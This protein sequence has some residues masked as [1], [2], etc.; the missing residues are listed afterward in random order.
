MREREVFC[1]GVS[2]SFTKRSKSFT[3][4]I[5]LVAFIATTVWTPGISHAAATM[6][7]GGQEVALPYQAAL[8]S[9]MRIE[10]PQTLGKIEDLHLGKGPAI[11]HIQT[12]HGHY[13][14]QQQIRQI[15]HHLEKNYGVTTV[16]VEGGISQL[17]PE[18]LNFFPQDKALTLKLNEALTKDAMVKGPELFLLDEIQQKKQYGVRST[19]DDETRKEYGVRRT[20]NEKTVLRS[21]VRRTPSAVPAVAYGIENAELY[22]ANGASFVDVLKQKE[23]TAN[24]LAQM[25]EGINRIS[26]HQLNDTLRRFIRQQEAFEK[27]LMPLDAWLSFMKDQAN[28][29]LKLDL[30]DAANQVEWPM[31]LRIFKLREISS[32]LDKNAFVMERK[33][34]LAAIKRF[35]STR[36]TEYGVRSNEKGLSQDAVRLTPYQSIETLLQSQSTSVQLPD[37]ETSF[38]FEDMVQRLPRDFNYDLFPNVR[39]FIGTLLLTSELKANRLMAETAKLADKISEG[40]AKTQAEKDLVGLLKDYRRLQKLFALELTP[41]DYEVI[42]SRKDGLKPS[43]IVKRF[44]STAYGLRS[45]AKTQDERGTP[46]AL[47]RTKTVVFAH[48][49]ELDLLYASALKF[50]SG[51]KERDGAMIRRIE[52]RLKET[53]A[54][55][56]AVITGGFHSKP[57]DDY[58]SSKD[59]T[60]ALI[61]PKITG[62]DKE[63]Y[64]NY[65]RNVLRTVAPRV[66]PV[67]RSKAPETRDPRSEIQ[68]TYEARYATEPG[69]PGV[70]ADAVLVAAGKMQMSRPT[71]AELQRRFQT[72]ARVADVAAQLEQKNRALIQAKSGIAAIDGRRSEHRSAGLEAPIKLSDSQIQKIVKRVRRVLEDSSEDALIPMRMTG[73]NFRLRDLNNVGRHNWLLGDVILRKENGR[74][75]LGILETLTGTV[76]SFR[77]YFVHRRNGDTARRVN[78]RSD[79]TGFIAVFHPNFIRSELRVLSP[80]S[81][82]NKIK[83][84][85]AADK[86]E[87]SQQ[88]LAMVLAD[89][90]EAMARK[91]HYVLGLATGS[92][93]VR[94]YELLV[95]AA[96]QGKIDFSKVTTFN[97]DEYEGL[98]PEYVGN[99]SPQHPGDP[100]VSYK[101]FMYKHFFR[102]LF[103][104]G[105]VTQDWINTHVN[106]FDSHS[107]DAEAMC[108]AYEAKIAELG[109][110]DTWIGG[111]GSDGHIAFNE[112]KGYRI[113]NGKQ[114]PVDS[115]TTPDSVSRRVHLP[116]MTEYANVGF[117]R[118]IG[119]DPKNGSRWVKWDRGR[120]VFVKP[121]TPGARPITRKEALAMVPKTAFSIGMRTY[122]NARHQI[123]LATGRGKADALHKGMD[124]APDNDVALSLLQEAA[125]CDLLVDTAAAVLL[126][127]SEGRDGGQGVM[128]FRAAQRLEEA[129]RQRE[130]AEAKFKQ[131]DAKLQ[132]ALDVAFPE[133]FLVGRTGELLEIVDYEGEGRTFTDGQGGRSALEAFR[134]AMQ[135][136]S[137]NRL[138]VF[139][140]TYRSEK[141]QVMKWKVIRPGIELLRGD[142][143]Q[144]KGEEWVLSG[145]VVNDKGDLE[146]GL[147][148]GQGV[149]FSVSR[150]ALN[151]SRFGRWGRWVSLRTKPLSAEALWMHLQDVFGG[152]VEW[153]AVAALGLTPVSAKMVMHH[154]RMAPAPIISALSDEDRLANALASALLELAETAGQ[155]GSFVRTAIGKNATLRA[156]SG[157]YPDFADQ[158][159]QMLQLEGLDSREVERFYK[160]YRNRIVK[161]LTARAEVRLKISGVIRSSSPEV[162]SRSEQ[163]KED[164]NRGFA[165][166][167]VETFNHTVPSSLFKVTVLDYY[168]SDDLRRKLAEAKEK[169]RL[170]EAAVRRVEAFNHAAP[171]SYFTVTVLHYNDADDLDRKL[172]SAREKLQVREAAVSRVEAFN[173]TVPSSMTFGVSVL[174]SDDAVDLD[175]KLESAREKLA[176][177]SEAPAAMLRTEKRTVQT[178]QDIDHPS[179]GNLRVSTLKDEDTGNSVTVAPELF[180]H[181]ISIKVNGGKTELLSPERGSWFMFPWSG[182]LE[183]EGQ[184]ITI[185]GEVVDLSGAPIDWKKDGKT[186]NH[187]FA[188]TRTPWKVI[189]SGRKQMTGLPMI[190][191]EIPYI[192]LELNTSDIQGVPEKFR[193]LRVRRTIFVAAN[194]EVAIQY[195]IENTGTIAKKVGFGEHLV[196]NTPNRDQWSGAPSWLSIQGL[197]G[198]QWDE[199]RPVSSGTPSGILHSSDYSILMAADPEVF[200]NQTFWTPEGK[201]YLG[202]EPQT[203]PPGAMDVTIQPGKTLRTWV[204]LFFSPVKRVSSLPQSQ[205]TGAGRGASTSSPLEWMGSPAQELN[206]A[207]AD[208]KTLLQQSWGIRPE[209]ITIEQPSPVLPHHAALRYVVIQNPEQSQ[210]SVT[211]GFTAYKGGGVLLSG[212]CFNNIDGSGNLMDEPIGTRSEKGITLTPRL[213]RPFMSSERVQNTLKHGGIG[214]EDIAGFAGRLMT[215]LQARPDYLVEV[216][217]AADTFH[218][219]PFDIMPGWRNVL[220][221]E[222]KSRDLDPAAFAAE[223]FNQ[224]KQ[225]VIDTLKSRAEGRAFGAMWKDLG[226]RVRD[227]AS[228]GA[229]WQQAMLS[230][231]ILPIGHYFTSRLELGDPVT[232]PFHSTTWFGMNVA[233]LGALVVTVFAALLVPKRYPTA[234][235]AAVLDE[236]SDDITTRA[237]MRV[238]VTAVTADHYKSVPTATAEEER[239]VWYHVAGTTDEGRSVEGLLIS[240]ADNGAT[241]YSKASGVRRVTFQKAPTVQQISYD[242]GFVTYREAYR[243]FRFQALEKRLTTISAA[244]TLA[245]GI[246]SLVFFPSL[247][248]NLVSVGAATLALSGVIF[249]GIFLASFFS[250]ADAWLALMTAVVAAA[251]VLAAALGLEIVASPFVAAAFTGVI[252]SGI[253]FFGPW[254]DPNFKLRSWWAGIHKKRIVDATSTEA[255]LNLPLG[256][257]SYHLSSLWWASLVPD[258]AN[259]A[260]LVAFPSVRLTRINATPEQVTR[261]AWFL[262]RKEVSGINYELFA[263]M[264]HFRL[265]GFNLGRPVLQG[266]LFVPK[267]SG[268]VVAI[269]IPGSFWKPSEQTIVPFAN[270]VSKAFNGQ[271]TLDEDTVFSGAPDKVDLALDG[272]DRISITRAE[273]RNRREVAADMLKVLRPMLAGYTPQTDPQQIWNESALLAT[274]KFWE[275]RGFQPRA[276]ASFAA[277]LY[278]EFHDAWIVQNEGSDSFEFFNSL[279]SHLNT[280]S[281]ASP[282]LRAKPMAQPTAWRAIQPQPGDK[283]KLSDGIVWTFEGFISG[284]GNIVKLRGPFTT[285]EMPLAQLKGSL[286]MT[287]EEVAKRS[288]WGLGRVFNRRGLELVPAGTQRT[289]RA[290]LRGFLGAIMLAGVL[291]LV[292]CQ[293]SEP[294]SEVPLAVEAAKQPSLLA[295][296]KYGDSG[297]TAGVL[298]TAN[299]KKNLLMIK[300]PGGEKIEEEVPAGKRVPMPTDRWANPMDSKHTGAGLIWVFGQGVQHDETAVHDNGAPIAVSYSYVDEDDGM[301]KTL[302]FSLKRRSQARKSDLTQGADDPAKLFGT[303]AEKR[304]KDRGGNPGFVTMLKAHGLLVRD[305]FVLLRWAGHWLIRIAIVAA[306]PFFSAYKINAFISAR[307]EPSAQYARWTI[308]LVTYGFASLVVG[309]I[310]YYGFKRYRPKLPLYR[311][312]I[313]PAVYAHHDFMNRFADGFGPAGHAVARWLETLSIRNHNLLIVAKGILKSPELRNPH[314]VLHQI[315]EVP[316]IQE[317]QDLRPANYTRGE[318]GQLVEVKRPGKPVVRQQQVKVRTESV[319]IE[320]VS[321]SGD[322][323]AVRL[324]IQQISADQENLKVEVDAAVTG[325]TVAGQGRDLPRETVLV[326]GSPD[327]EKTVRQI[328]ENVFPY[329]QSFTYKSGELDVL[330]ELL[331]LEDDIES[332]IGRGEGDTVAGLLNRAEEI[333]SSSRKKKLFGEFL[334]DMLM[335]RFRSDKDRPLAVQILTGDQLQGPIA[336]VLGAALKSVM[337]KEFVQPRPQSIAALRNQGIRVPGYFLNS[338]T[339]RGKTGS[340]FQFYVPLSGSPILELPADDAAMDTQDAEQEQELS[341]D[342]FAAALIEGSGL[343]AERLAEEITAAVDFDSLSPSVRFPWMD[344]QARLAPSDDGGPVDFSTFFTDAKQAVLE[345]LA[346]PRAEARQPFVEGWKAAVKGTFALSWYLYRQAQEGLFDVLVGGIAGLFGTLILVPFVALFYPLWR[347]FGPEDI[348][349]D[350]SYA[351]VWESLQELIHHGEQGPDALDRPS[352]NDDNPGTN[353]R[354][355][356][357]VEL[358]DKSALTKLGSPEEYQG[359]Y[360]FGDLMERLA[361]WLEVWQR[362]NPEVN[363]FA[364]SPAADKILWA[365]MGASFSQDPA[366]WVA[367]FFEALSRDHKWSL[368]PNQQVRLRIRRYREIASIV[369]RSMIELEPVKVAVT[370]EVPVQP[371][372]TQSAA[373]SAEAVRP[374]FAQAAPPVVQAQTATPVVPNRNPVP[375]PAGAP[376]VRMADVRGS[377]ALAPRMA[378]SRVSVAPASR[379]SDKE[380]SLHQY[381][382][383]NLKYY[384]WG[385]EDP[386][387]KKASSSPKSTLGVVRPVI[388]SPVQVSAV[389]PSVSAANTAPQPVRPGARRVVPVAAQAPA[390]FVGSLQRL[391]MQGNRIDQKKLK[392]I[393][394]VWMAVVSKIPEARKEHYYAFLKALEKGLGKSTFFEGLNGT[395]ATK[396]EI[397]AKVREADRVH[398]QTREIP[399]G[400]ETIA[401][402]IRDKYG[403]SESR[404]QQSAAVRM[405]ELLSAGDNRSAAEAVTLVVAAY[406]DYRKVMDA[407][408]V[409]KATRRAAEKEWHGLA[410]AFAQAS[411]ESRD[412]FSYASIHLFQGAVY[413]LV[414]GA[415]Q[416]QVDRAD[417]QRFFKKLAGWTVAGIVLGAALVTPN[418]G[419]T[420]AILLAAFAIG[421]ITIPSARKFFFGGFLRQYF[422]VMKAIGAM[423]PG[424]LDSLSPKRALSRRVKALKA[425]RYG[426]DS[427][428]PFLVQA[429]KDENLP[430]QLKDENPP[431]LLKDEN[432]SL[433]LLTIAA[434]SQIGYGAAPA[435]LA[436]AIGNI[437]PLLRA[438]AQFVLKVAARDNLAVRFL[439]ESRG[440]DWYSD[441]LNDW[442][443]ASGRAETRTAAELAVMVLERLAIIDDA[444]VWGLTREVVRAGVSSLDEVREHLAETSAAHRDVFRTQKFRQEHLL[445]KVR[446]WGVVTTIVLSLGA[447]AVTFGGLAAWTSGLLIAA[448]A[449]FALSFLIVPYFFRSAIRRATEE[450]AEIDSFSKK[451]QLALKVIEGME[452]EAGRAGIPFSD[453]VSK[454]QSQYPRLVQ[455][456]LAEE[457]SEGKVHGWADSRLHRSETR[458][459]ALSHEAELL[460][461][462]R[463]VLDHLKD[464]RAFSPIF[465]Y[466]ALAL[467]NK[468]HPKEKL[469]IEQVATDP[470][471]HAKMRNWVTD[472]FGMEVV[473]GNMDIYMLHEA[474]LK[475]NGKKDLRPEFNDD[476]SLAPSQLLY[477][478]QAGI[479]DLDNLAPAKDVLEHGRIK[480]LAEFFSDMKDQRPGE[481]RIAK[482]IAP[483]SLA[484][485]LMDSN[486]MSMGLYN[487]KEDQHDED[488]VKFQKVMKYAEDVV[489]AVSEYLVKEGHVDGIVYL[490]PTATGLAHNKLFDLDAYEKYGVDPVGRLSELLHGLGALSGYHPCCP[491][492]DRDM[493]QQIMERFTKIKGLDILSIDAVYENLAEIYDYLEA[494]HAGEPRRPVLMGNLNTEAGSE[495]A[496]KDEAAVIAAVEKLFRDMGTRGFI[497]ATS[498]DLNIAGH[499]IDRMGGLDAYLDQLEKNIM[500]FSKRSGELAKRFRSESRDLTKQSVYAAA[501]QIALQ[502]VQR[503]EFSDLEPRKVLIEIDGYAGIRRFSRTVEVEDDDLR[504][505][506]LIPDE[507]SINLFGQAVPADIEAMINSHLSDAKPSRFQVFEAGTFKSKISGGSIIPVIRIRQV[508]DD[509]GRR[510]PPVA[511]R[512]GAKSKG[513]TG[514]EEDSLF[515]GMETVISDDSGSRVD[516]VMIDGHPVYFLSNAA[517]HE[518]EAT[519]LGAN[520]ISLLMKQPDGSRVQRIWHKGKGEK[521]LD[522]EGA[523]FG[524]GSAVM[525]PWTTRGP[526]Q[527]E[528]RGKTYKID[529][530]SKLT[531]PIGPNKE[532]GLHGYFARMKW[533]TDEATDIRIVDGVPQISFHLKTKD[534]PEL[535]AEDFHLGDAELILTYKLGDSGVT[536]EIKIINNNPYPIFLNFGLH[537]FFLL[538][539]I[540]DWEV[541][542]EASKRRLVTSDGMNA[543]TVETVDVAG[544]SEDLSQGLPLKQYIE[545]LYTGLTFGADGN[546]TAY[547]YNKKT[548]E[549]LSVTQDELFGSRTAWV[550]I[551]IAGIEGV[552]SI[553]PTTGAGIFDMI[554]V[555]ENDSVL[556][557]MAVTSKF[558]PRAEVRSPSFGERVWM[559][560][561]VTGIFM[562][563]LSVAAAPFIKPVL[564]LA[565][566]AAGAWFAQ[567]Q[568][569]RAHPEVASQGFFMMVILCLYVSSIGLPAFGVYIFAGAVEV[570]GGAFRDHFFPQVIRTTGEARMI[571]YHLAGVRAGWEEWIGNRELQGRAEARVRVLVNQLAEKRQIQQVLFVLPRDGTNYVHLDPA[572]KWKIAKAI[573]RVAGVIGLEKFLKG[574]PEVYGEVQ[575]LD[576]YLVRPLLRKVRNYESSTSQ[577]IAAEIPF[578]MTRAETRDAETIM[579]EIGDRVPELVSVRAAL[580]QDDIP[581]ALNRMAAI[582]EQYLR[583]DDALYALLLELSGSITKRS[584]GRSTEIIPGPIEVRLREGTA[585]RFYLPL[586]ET[587]IQYIMTETGLSRAQVETL[588]AQKIAEAAAA[589]EASSK[590]LD[591]SEVR[592][593]V[594]VLAGLM[595]VTSAIAF[596]KP[597][598]TRRAAELPG[599]TFIQQFERPVGKS[600]GMA[601]TTTGMTNLAYDPAVVLAN[602][603]APLEAK[604]KAVE[605]LGKI[606]NAAS[607]QVLFT[608]WTDMYDSGG[609][610]REKIKDALIGMSGEVAPIAITQYFALRQ[611]F[612]HRPKN[613]GGHI[614]MEATGDLLGQLENPEAQF[615]S[616]LIQGNIAAA[617][618]VPGAPEFARRHLTSPDR[619]LRTRAMKT[620]EVLRVTS[621]SDF[622]NYHKTENLGMLILGIIGLGFVAFKIFGNIVMNI[623]ILRH[624]VGY[625]VEA[626]KNDVTRDDAVEELIKLGDRALPA[627]HELLAQTDLDLE[628][629]HAAHRVLA[630]SVAEPEGEDL[631]RAEKRAFAP[632]QN[633]VRMISGI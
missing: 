502:A 472:H 488:F 588:V 586:S 356:T 554:K 276:V 16:L 628:I 355:E 444:E 424:L 228:L 282:K 102:P 94:L 279:V 334:R 435:L 92:T 18:R 38:L 301:S 459:S 114:V 202:L 456:V 573:V 365:R 306:A 82:T 418:P 182:A 232:S 350:P 575:Y 517:G 492:H 317:I 50:Y 87:V 204:S 358:Q 382:T 437:K 436:E 218:D 277:G 366:E 318:D 426:D 112:P 9:A 451:S 391:A 500:A 230:W 580:K 482:V 332:A 399:P 321:P 589:R 401:K 33:E 30:T 516:R 478:D 236:V 610:L 281:T 32:K 210:A 162:S 11:F 244:V 130:L 623:F 347:A 89:Y 503:A 499:V 476:L 75:I 528:A 461:L 398:V 109:G 449:V 616:F 542:S 62:A 145:R 42:L 523:P 609:S 237:E 24:F 308:V 46:Y 607:A 78:H 179:Y 302:T 152:S 622:W 196:F 495:L 169:L 149:P 396:L 507:R 443:L 348:E 320:C 1:T 220:A 409:D 493:N 617:A 55:R 412:R 191:G 533:T 129:N 508:V 421:G 131:A 294:A 259:L 35:M 21:A 359:F 583:A 614:L 229:G 403:R 223:F 258:T 203:G 36:S 159:S 341:A 370:H 260:Y 61:S 123:V 373:F 534:Y 297:P 372:V 68:S 594:V 29:V 485:M 227:W 239:R 402:A 626:L 629:Q 270:R 65:I 568:M 226:W 134:A 107:D 225:N 274:R 246:F 627:I 143:V 25:E 13:Q 527:F 168:D 631:G 31:M 483:M 22:E 146:L 295:H 299:P 584:E 361:D 207:A 474:I 213:I 85:V 76:G 600:R 66:S 385:D 111:L 336:G 81:E 509:D 296:L 8:G 2:G 150:A 136:E 378:A 532:Y 17:D 595:S 353:R 139:N 154:P 574:K 327:I 393:Q 153:A 264:A 265:L 285:R 425:F 88:A 546:S 404:D 570:I 329:T 122:L 390:K 579:R 494:I 550:P 480:A 250:R 190:E 346:N 144:W 3:A 116:W 183:A 181:I 352:P 316:A 466:A 199:S 433:Q 335:R 214:S 388:P 268:Q 56:V 345:A 591:R 364:M 27:N 498:C 93:P 434:L 194:G 445:P 464:T 602:D 319:V 615:Y 394:D 248:L 28:Q 587:T 54:D 351:H 286:V 255:G 262:N 400:Y 592:F 53:G 562:G 263:V 529:T 328:L 110:V 489:A 313:T 624:P 298:A 314:I 597:V 561:K 71:I 389:A 392:K 100:D 360:R 414:H 34:F 405:A 51:V 221:Q 161:A 20:E 23:T 325:P 288:T 512:F 73:A 526:A 408:D 417:R 369:D 310:L 462:R 106:I 278:R 83:L 7:I 601:V 241:I 6:P 407:P 429:L 43:E 90:N 98:P 515:E 556:G 261:A 206:K 45:T 604:T 197:K 148:S 505:L 163:R 471:A 438:A 121:G 77:E 406:Q 458:T 176:L 460:A 59:Y 249:F 531:R 201:D 101:A 363:A 339:I 448:G 217:E 413:D 170:R 625:W 96:A 167:E 173:H 290:E 630:R 422:R 79:E 231:A 428:I 379:M 256:E 291:G 486:E 338:L 269:T 497:V 156:L 596:T 490:E 559:A 608:A 343:D 620:L 315:K 245:L 540:Q 238:E 566:A 506:A 441:D 619:E 187:G 411:K 247:F 198:A 99:M 216:L 337:A 452:V 324:S 603:K 431:L 367:G 430:L 80:Y 455:D 293:V 280:M 184:K 442:S 125:N 491:G 469:T 212:R 518:A 539:N 137:P 599:G 331:L 251:G 166:A 569:G 195:E 504:D 240:W 410:V 386:E 384:L 312:V 371:P 362:Q 563:K 97:M 381:W 211:L 467:Y 383:D 585:A 342:G 374:P 283:V 543:P 578:W 300:L 558:E 10:V 322:K 611:E 60:Y 158:I 189:D 612:G 536:P 242:P 479:T 453:F 174:P 67:A 303:R 52:E 192:T 349:H 613:M 513:F 271:R 273:M 560:T 501:L 164:P 208:L 463:E 172:E 142:H 287:K 160:D 64:E 47:H 537:F 311:K 186:A 473:M 377:A 514:R 593:P 86:E 115:G 440:L 141:R 307:L 547:F 257:D 124:L 511:R 581:E 234:R 95:E 548:G 380:Q 41:A 354:N 420:F 577:E 58:F 454:I 447:V 175:R 333:L 598:E 215:A 375:R 132:A 70:P 138:K 155:G 450:I 289:N 12:A 395:R 243:A 423:Q 253:S 344:V 63:G 457:A 632:A 180:G 193:D 222:A 416:E 387:V 19:V 521:L 524:G 151:G 553:Q 292:S 535:L 576:D 275:S 104:K 113:E 544:T 487:G 541:F 633:A 484:V 126:E 475:A 127:R 171:S 284:G 72:R 209:F 520:L 224:Y 37:P 69:T 549:I 252:F 15:L 57:F 147:L 525:G 481:P 235:P 74:L 233:L 105:L 326:R 305:L 118:F 618:E 571:A 128:D 133:R 157:E 496:E 538:E 376:G 44:S 330:R 555:P 140:Q 205:A 272:K 621:F 26:A 200:L 567:V 590:P 439:L 606:K 552:A 178:E 39:Y 582:E 266:I 84:T 470:K 572:T 477:L 4:V 427:A 103:D 565:A 530:G 5:T 340:F 120:L 48:T 323:L 605:D 468:H 419:L 545:Q 117:F 432:L 551:G 415:F 309:V 304:T 14:A 40:L 219:L 185:D 119:R 165:L 357:R 519:T 368:D 557:T 177:Q 49:A 108:A 446:K 267:T 397:L 254:K 91:G 510:I 522:A 188:R 564:V 465:G 135:D